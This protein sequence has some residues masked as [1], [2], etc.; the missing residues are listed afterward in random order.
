MVLLLIL[1]IDMYQICYVYH[2]SFTTAMVDIHISE[3]DNRQCFV[4]EEL[5]TE[6]K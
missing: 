4:N 3:S 6:T 2:F 5:G 1:A